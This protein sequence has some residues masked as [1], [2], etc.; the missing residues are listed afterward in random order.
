MSPSANACVLLRN[1]TITSGVWRIWAPASKLNY[2]RARQ[3]WKRATTGSSLLALVHTDCSLG[4][5]RCSSLAFE[6]TKSCWTLALPA[7][8]TPRNLRACTSWYVVLTRLAT[9]TE[10]SSL[11]VQRCFRLNESSP[12]SRFDVKLDP[13]PATAQR[14]ARSY[15]A[16]SSDLV[17]WLHTGTGL[18]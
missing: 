8:A 5:H 4:V 11:A 7:T 10:C 17:C 14:V 12:F 15:L 3:R 13:R 9:C 1:T 2:K 18:Y 16:W 6:E